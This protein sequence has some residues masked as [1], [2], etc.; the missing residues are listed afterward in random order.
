MKGAVCILFNTTFMT[1]HDRIK[2]NDFGYAFANSSSI[3]CKIW[4]LTSD[5]EGLLVQN[6]DHRNEKQVLNA[7]IFWYKRKEDDDTLSKQA[8]LL[9]ELCG[10]W[11]TKQKMGKRRIWR[12]WKNI[13]IEAS[14]YT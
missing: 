7:M 2:K 3:V 1:L 12:D 13:I 10:P 14:I 8:K 6:P 4:A 5:W 11:K 9:R